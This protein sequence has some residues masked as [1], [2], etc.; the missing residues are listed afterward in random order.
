MTPDQIAL[1][2]TWFVVF[3]FS[4]TLHEAG[5]AYDRLT[6]AAVPGSLAA[7]FAVPLSI[8]FTLNIL[9]T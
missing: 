2:L 4:T 5:H 7:A 3:L 8:F 6:E 1:G 9:F